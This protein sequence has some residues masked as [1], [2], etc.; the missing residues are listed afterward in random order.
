MAPIGLKVMKEALLQ[1]PFKVGETGQQAFVVIASSDIDTE[2]LQQKGF[3]TSQLLGGNSHCR[4]L[5]NALDR[6]ATRDVWQRSGMSSQHSKLALCQV[7]IDS[8][9]CIC[10]ASLQKVSC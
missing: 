9:R 8:W 3:R 5:L 7:T 1:G 4:A 2:D 10:E 6:D